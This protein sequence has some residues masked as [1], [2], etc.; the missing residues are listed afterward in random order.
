MNIQFKPVPDMEAWLLK[1][2][3]EGFRTIPS[4]V[5]EIVAE[6]M[7]QELATNDNKSTTETGAAQ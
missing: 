5:K 6:K 4:V 2:A 3:T 1:K 7:R